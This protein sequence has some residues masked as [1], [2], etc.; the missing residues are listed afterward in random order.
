MHLVSLGGHTVDS[1]HKFGYNTDV[2][3]AEDIWDGGGDYPWP[4]A[5]ATTTIESSDTSDTSAGTG[6]RTVKVYGLDANYL[7]ISETVTLNGTSQVTLANDYLRLHRAKVLTAGSNG[8]N[9]GN[10]LLKHG[11]TTIAQISADR[12]QTLMAIFT[13]ANDVSHAEIAQW[14]AT[15]GRDK[16]SVTQ[17]AL[18]MR[19]YGGAW[20]TKELIDVTDTSPALIYTYPFWQTV[21]AR[22][23]IRV[24]ALS[25]SVADVAIGAGFDLA[26]FHN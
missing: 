22:T 3:A 11:A 6:A 13:I 10:L 25:V 18:M 1:I 12:G 21:P 7:Q 19:E 9:A 15:A 20:Q 16:T 14:Y 23:D 26:I 24:R 17:M 4:S 5:A 2:D 8:I